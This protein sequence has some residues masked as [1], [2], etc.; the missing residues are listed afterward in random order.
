[1]SNITASQAF[2]LICEDLVFVEVAFSEH[3]K[4]KYLYKIHKTQLKEELA[5]ASIEVLRN[6]LSGR[7]AIVQAN[8]N[9]D[10]LDLENELDVQFALVRILNVLDKSEVDF[11]Q[12]KFSVRFITSIVDFTQ[13]EKLNNIQREFVK[14]FNIERN[15]VMQAQLMQSIFGDTAQAQLMA[16]SDKTKI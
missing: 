13:V 16:L 9:R 4:T 15:K 3:T 1:M 7:Y 14:S 2:D 6:E 8:R 12:Q 5:S 10:F 11:T